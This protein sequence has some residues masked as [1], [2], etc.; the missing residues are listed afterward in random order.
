MIPMIEK[1][2]RIFGMPLAS[3]SFEM[4]NKSMDIDV[5]RRTAP[6]HPQYLK[7]ADESSMT[8]AFLHQSADK[9]K[10]RDP[11]PILPSLTF[12]ILFN[13]RRKKVKYLEPPPQLKH[14][15]EL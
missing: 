10:S 7:I 8:K 9:P 4:S 5:K 14:P 15:R 13:T 3:L 2:H 11:D 6:Q 12:Y 1:W